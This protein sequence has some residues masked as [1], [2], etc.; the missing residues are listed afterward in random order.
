MV[1]QLTRAKEEEGEVLIY[2]N[3]VIYQRG[4]YWQFRMWLA[5]ENKY[6]RK[7]LNT[8]NKMIALERGKEYYLEIMSI[9][10]F[11]KSTTSL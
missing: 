8:K 2:D 11:S 7:S 9:K 4:E 6:A 1:K 5:N 10:L 3:A